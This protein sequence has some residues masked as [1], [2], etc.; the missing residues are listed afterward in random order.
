VICGYVYIEFLQCKSILAVVEY[1]Y[2]L[3]VQVAS[4][5]WLVPGCS[6]ET[7]QPNRVGIAIGNGHYVYPVTFHK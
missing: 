6:Q 3:Q 7:G 5:S 2:C 1:I 4:K